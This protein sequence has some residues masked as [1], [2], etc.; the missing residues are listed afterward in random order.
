MKPRILIIDDSED[1]RDLI[2]HHLRGQ[3]IELV[4]AE[5][6]EEGLRVL[7]ATDA[8]INMVLLDLNMPGMD[9]F[10][11]LDHIRNR[12]FEDRKYPRN[13]RKSHAANLREAKR[14]DE[15]FH[16]RLRELNVIVISA[17]HQ[18]QDVL[19]AR[20][21]NLAGYLVKPFTRETLF[22]RINEASGQ[23]AVASAKPES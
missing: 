10:Q 5:S 3:P 1:V 6:G 16:A 20:E 22:A 12:R 23:T 2:R 11:F 13:P 15:E 18:A 7:D 8:I 14:Q 4:V 21:F 17:R 9:G 19:K